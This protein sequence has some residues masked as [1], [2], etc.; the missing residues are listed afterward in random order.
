[1]FFKRR[2]IGA[3][4]FALA[5][6]LSV[7]ACFGITQVNQ[8]PPPPSPTNQLPPSPT[9]Q[10]PPSVTPSPISTDIPVVPS[11]LVSTETPPVT[12]QLNILEINGFKDEGNY[13]Y[14][15]GLVRNDTNRTINELQIE[16][17]LL[18][19]TGAEVYNYT[20]YSTLYN[21]APGET[22]PFSDF[23]TEPFPDGKTMQATVAGYNSSEAV[24]RV[25]LEYRGITMWVDANH[26]IYLAGEVINVSE[27][28][29]K[30]NAIAGS[31]ADETG[32][33]VT[34]SYAYPFLSYVEPNGSS[35]FVMMFNAPIGQAGSLT[36]Y[37]LYSDA[38]VTIPIST[39]AISLSEK[40]NEYQD[41]N[42]DL[43]LVG[44]ATNNTNKLI[45]IYLVVGAYDESGN[46]VDA[47]SVYLPV[48]L[49][50][51]ETIPY[52]FTIWGV[53]DNVPAAYD[54]ASQFK[55]YIDWISTTEASSK[56][57]T[58]ITKDDTN[59][60]IGSVGIFNGTVVN[61]SGQDLTTVIVVVT[62]YDKSNGELIATSYAY[63]MESM[64]NNASGTYE[65]YL[66]PPNSIDPANVNIVITAL[67]Q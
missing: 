30:I 12:G 20:T 67:G 29:A 19:S 31:L 57:Y 44:S 26:D 63:V 33:L 37:T 58:L 62:L 49:N 45:N 15:Y 13:W 27:D 66:Y 7:M 25:N 23:T 60:F 55:I 34:V 4:I 14:F 40:H 3:S 9:I 48:P 1:M 43:H 46:C 6:A 36:N 22:S 38:I 39:F 10:P 35:P 8:I 65:V 59:A 5:L 61:N 32:K 17:K 50:P 41:I 52:D 42:G 2:Q 47:N 56:A 16:V 51:G 21:L 18:D 64:V 11:T 54:A 28:P 24:I 53:M